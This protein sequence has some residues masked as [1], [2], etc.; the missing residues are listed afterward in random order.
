MPEIWFANLGVKI[1]HLNRIAFSIFGIDVYW[2]GIIIATGIVLGLLLIMKE[3][4]R[5]GQN[6]E[7]YSDG[8][9]FTTIISLISARTYYVLFSWDYFKD[10]LD[11]IFSIRDGGIAIYGAIIGGTITIIIYSRI[12]KVNY[13]KV[14][15]TVVFG[16][17]V[18]QILGRFGNFVNREAFGGYTDSLFAMRYLKEQV[19]QANL[20][21][22][23]IENVITV[24]GTQYISVH[25][26]FLYESMWNLTLLIILFL[27]RKKKKFNGEIMAMYFVGYGIGRFWI[28]GLRTDA[29]LI[30][31]TNFAVSRVLS[32]VLS[33]VFIIY[34]F[35][36]RRKNKILTRYE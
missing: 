25:P 27:Y 29:L 11:K 23:I 9:I 5:T 15:D 4:K 7:F 19:A 21:P 13:L 35:I 1:N 22:N 20:T 33:I 26:T 2:Y 14:G 32:L 6:P 3:A 36:N 17:L 18:G 24:N 30:G 8:L 31:H 16:L 28:E 34:I 12:K 10:N